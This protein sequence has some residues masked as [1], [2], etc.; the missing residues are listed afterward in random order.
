MTPT[1]TL[2]AP[3]GERSE[4]KKTRICEPPTAVGEFLPFVL[5]YLKNDGKMKSADKLLDMG[6][7]RIKDQVFRVRIVCM[8]IIKD[9]N[10]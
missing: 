7:P 6:P 8:R 1:A 10:H 5:L 3:V 2:N 4:K 9:Q